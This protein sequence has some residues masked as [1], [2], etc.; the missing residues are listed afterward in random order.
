MIAR[1]TFLL[2]DV[3]AYE[4]LF[5]MSEFDRAQ[6]NAQFHVVDSMPKARKYV[7][8]EGDYRDRGKHPLP[9]FILLDLREPAEEGHEFLAWLRDKTP[10]PTRFIPV[11]LMSA[12]APPERVARAYELGANWYVVKESEGDKFREQI[13]TLAAFWGTTGR[14]NPT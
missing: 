7:A 11:V 8:G 10:G 9:D 12:A 4:A 5:I 14:A 13:K 2:V 6:S 3:D 1:A